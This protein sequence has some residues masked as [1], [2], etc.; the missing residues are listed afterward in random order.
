MTTESSAIDSRTVLPPD[1]QEQEDPFAEEVNAHYGKTS[2]AD[3]A[4]KR[5]GIFGRRGSTEKDNQPS[6][7]SWLF[8]SLLMVLFLVPFAISAVLFLIVQQ[9]SVQLD[10]L[11]AAF[12]HGQLQQLPAEMQALDAK[13]DQLRSEFITVQAFDKLRQ[14]QQDLARSL[15]EKLKQYSES[16]EQ[17]L[18]I[19]EHLARLEQRINDLQGIADAHDKRISALASDWQSKWETLASQKATTGSG[20]RSVKKPQ[21]VIKPVPA[22]FTLTSIEHRGGQQYAVIIPQVSA[23]NRWSDIRMLTPGQSVDGWT[24]ASIDGNQARFLVNG[25][26]H[27]LTLQ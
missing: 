14:S 9:Q 1:V 27:I 12:R 21:R 6:R 22:P 5:M 26:P 13:V 24:L 10:S 8:K 18:A 11:D 3:V 19:P 7:L 20:N 23:G 16:V 25:K 2:S 4:A 15:D 17:Q